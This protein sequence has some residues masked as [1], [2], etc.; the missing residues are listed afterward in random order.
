MLI[1]YTDA[2]TGNS[3]AINPEHVVCV[4]TNK[5]ETTGLTSTIINML[6]GNIAVTEEY[7]EVV[8]RIQGE[9]K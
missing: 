6:N 7:S 3:V 4:F 2:T 8:G 5:D 9:L 1:I